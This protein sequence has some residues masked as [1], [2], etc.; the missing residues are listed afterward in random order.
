MIETDPNTQVTYMVTAPLYGIRKE[1]EMEIKAG[2]QGTFYL[3]FGKT[4][5]D[6][7]F[8]HEVKF[9][10]EDAEFLLGFRDGITAYFE[11]LEVDESAD[12]PELAE[13]MAP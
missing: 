4:F 8:W 10:F 11:A 1:A 7:T 2:V 12:A 5:P 6:G 3:S 9:L 13:V